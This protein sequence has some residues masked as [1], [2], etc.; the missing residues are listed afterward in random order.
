[1]RRDLVDAHANS[2]LI[3]VRDLNRAFRGPRILFGYY[4]GGLLCR[5]LIDR[6]GFPPMLRLLEAF[7]RG[8]DLDRAFGEVYGA[9]PEQIDREFEAFVRAQLQ[10][11]AIEPRWS[12]T[13]IAK[14][15]LGLAREAP[16]DAAELE[17]WKD[18]WCTVAWG[19][20]Q[21]GRQV[22]AQQALRRVTAVGEPPPRALF[23]RAEMA[24]AAGDDA[25]AREAYLAG[26]DAGGRD[27]R[28]RMALGRLALQDDDLE[29]AVEHFQAAEALFP[30]Y[31]DK[32]LA[33]E[34]FLAETLGRL[35]RTDEMYRARER[36]LAWN[37]DE[38]AMRMEL[39][40]WHAREARPQEAVR[41]FEEVNE[42]DPFRRALHVEWG[43]VLEALERYEEALREFRV[44]LLVPV[45]LDLDQ[46]GPPDDE[47]RAR[48]LT[49]Q[50]R[51]LG[52]LGRK[53]E[54]AAT[55]AQ[56]LELDPQND[57]ARAIAAGDA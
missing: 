42:I 50:A 38:Y 57:E 34:L 21:T 24:L 19:W 27:F 29:G 33:A 9:T 47:E 3:G 4:Q 18:G 51:M 55:A 28:A 26:V 45:D 1:M 22:D 56:A 6:H 13:T 10:G 37:A 41:W 53:V 12:P 52:K 40:R 25:G 54:S 44:A 49:A 31:P 32:P 11:I 35:D 36:W 20:W 48:L 43:E 30:G 17:S 16:A 39:A 46:A 2:A 5:M 15:R 8:L 14:L 7:D 23:L